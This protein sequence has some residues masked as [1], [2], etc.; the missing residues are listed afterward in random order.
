[1]LTALNIRGIQ[2]D[3]RNSKGSSRPKKGLLVLVERP[4]TDATPAGDAVLYPG[5]HAVEIRHVED[6]GAAGLLLTL[7][8]ASRPAVEAARLLL[9]AQAEMLVSRWA[10]VGGSSLAGRHTISLLPRPGRADVPV[11]ETACT[12]RA[13]SSVGG[14]DIYILEAEAPVPL[15]PGRRYTFSDGTHALCI[16]SGPRPR[17]LRPAELA[18]TARG[19]D[20]L[21]PHAIEELYLTIYGLS[22]RLSDVCPHGSHLFAHWITTEELIDEVSELLEEVLASEPEVPVAAARELAE[23]DRFFLPRSLWRELLAEIERRTGIERRRGVLHA[24]GGGARG[25]QHAGAQSRG[26]ALSPAERAVLEDIAAAGTHGEHVKSARI[27]NA[28]PLVERLCERALVVKLPNGRLYDRA[29]F[30]RLAAVEGEIDERGAAETWGVSRN[31]ARLL[32]DRM[33]AEG[34][35]QRT[36]AKTVVASRE[37]GRR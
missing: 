34:L 31:T 15:F 8:G 22:P 28:K 32:I 1:M 16:L 23:S 9:P 30:E 36:S 10:V 27:G 4:G 20:A 12:L 25:M 18:E 24:P 37:G 26:T 13:V 21:D 6:R 2:P 5:G 3:R 29:A 33:V 17:H 14:L 7:R 11:V 19:T 35:M